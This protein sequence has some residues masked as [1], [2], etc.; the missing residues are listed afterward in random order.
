MS[1]MEYMIQEKVCGPQSKR[2]AQNT[3]YAF[4][5]QNILDNHQSQIP[6]LTQILNSQ[7]TRHCA[8]IE[9][10]RLYCILGQHCTSETAEEFLVTVT[11]NLCNSAAAE[12]WT[13]RNM[14]RAIRYQR[15]R[16]KQKMQAK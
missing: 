5:A 15:M 12:K 1:E 6:N 8:L 10:G 2:T 7:K 14:E 11:N 4:M 13:T 9:L 3:R 16:I